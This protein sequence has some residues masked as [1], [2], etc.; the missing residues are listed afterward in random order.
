MPAPIRVRLLLSRCPTSDPATRGN[1]GTRALSLSLF[2]CLCFSLSLSHS[3]S[4]RLCFSSA[5]PLLLRSIDLGPVVSVS[6]AVAPADGSSL[7][8]EG[9]STSRRGPAVYLP[10]FIPALWPCRRSLGARYSEP[11]RLTP[12]KLNVRQIVLP[13]RSILRS[14]VEM[15]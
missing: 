13:P 1:D 15:R 7:V 5:F 10:P 9:R 3:H 8:A 4:P 6:N 14:S 11:G 2:L 12:W